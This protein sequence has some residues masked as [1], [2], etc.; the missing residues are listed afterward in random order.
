MNSEFVLGHIDGSD[1]GAAS[2]GLQSDADASP[3][4]QG[5]PNIAESLGRAGAWEL[6]D[7]R[8]QMRMLVGKMTHTEQL[9]V[10]KDLN[11]Q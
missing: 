10:Q 5:L 2:K 1:R 6:V 7:G 9:Q 3:L 4:S 8:L 11:N